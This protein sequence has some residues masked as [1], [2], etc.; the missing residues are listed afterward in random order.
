MSTICLF[1]NLEGDNRGMMKGQYSEIIT[2][3]FPNIRISKNPI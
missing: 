2:N 1:G 3:D